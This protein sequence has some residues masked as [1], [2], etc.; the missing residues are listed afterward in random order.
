MESHKV[1]ENGWN[2][3]AEIVRVIDGDTIVVQLTRTIHI[4]LLDCWCAE[5]RTKDKSEKVLGLA[6]KQ[7][8]LDLVAKHG[9]ICTVHIHAD[10]NEDVSRTFTMS[11]ALGRVWLS[12]GDEVS[13]LMRAAGHAVATK[14]E[15]EA[16]K[17]RSK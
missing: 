10:P 11:R 4:R 2:T 3:P 16:R 7:H 8:L 5:S 15:Q 14:D 17:A 9:P 12:N 1:P 6:A 13:E